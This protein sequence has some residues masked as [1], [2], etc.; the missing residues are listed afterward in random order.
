MKAPQKRGFVL[1]V[2]TNPNG[3]ESQIDLYKTLI[4]SIGI[5]IL[6]TL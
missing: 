5:I 6:E 1:R 2:P 4:L 3:K